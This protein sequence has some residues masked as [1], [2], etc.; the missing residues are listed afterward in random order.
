MIADE[1]SKFSKLKARRG[2]RAS[3]TSIYSYRHNC[4]P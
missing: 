1:K 2:I 3:P 4:I